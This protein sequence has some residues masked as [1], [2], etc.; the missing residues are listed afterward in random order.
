M[1]SLVKT[2]EGNDGS[3]SSPSQVTQDTF[4]C[5]PLQAS[6]HQIHAAR[7]SSNTNV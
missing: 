6:S 1:F 2:N 7:F 4:A 5:I 3:A